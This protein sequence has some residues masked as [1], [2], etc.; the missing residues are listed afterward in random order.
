MFYYYCCMMVP[1]FFVSTRV[2]PP[3]WLTQA[4]GMFY[5]DLADPDYATNFCVYHRRFRCRV[6]VFVS[7]ETV[8][9][10]VT[11]LVP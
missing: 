4:L 6:V 10:F 11:R 7:R 1:H 8:F 3:F 2:P 9:S 5:K